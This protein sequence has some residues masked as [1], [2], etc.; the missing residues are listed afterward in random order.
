MDDPQAVP[1]G[2]EPVLKDDEII[3]K[4]TSASFGYRI[5]S[6]LALAYLNPDRLNHQDQETVQV[7]IAG[8][9]FSGSVFQKAAFEP[10]GKKMKIFHNIFDPI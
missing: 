4:T 1:L 6:P 8:Q 7:D 10:S 5:G 2:N 3:G 9:H